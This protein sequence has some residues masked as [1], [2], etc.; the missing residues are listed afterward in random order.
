MKG[1]ESFVKHWRILYFIGDQ[2]Y[3]VQDVVRSRQPIKYARIMLGIATRFE[4]ELLG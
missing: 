4:I 2:L 3:D 1:G